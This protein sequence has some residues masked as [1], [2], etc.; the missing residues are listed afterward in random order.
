MTENDQGDLIQ[1]GRRYPGAVVSLAFST[2]RSRSD[3]AITSIFAGLVPAAGVFL[4]RYIVLKNLIVYNESSLQP[5][6]QKKCAPMK[7][8]VIAIGS[9]GD[10]NPFLVLAL[11]LKSAKA[12]RWCFAALRITGS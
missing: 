8:M 9:R 2:V 5:S 4:A 7:I 3:F 1:R 10:V 12:M 6:L 11:R